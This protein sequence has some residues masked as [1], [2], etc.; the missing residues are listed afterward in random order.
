MSDH[1]NIE[2]VY[3]IGLGALGT[4]Y[5]AKFHD[6]LP[7][8]L[9]IIANEERQRSLK[10]N[11]P[12]VN[13]QEYSFNYITPMEQP[14]TT[15]DLIII[16]VKSSQLDQAIQ[17]IQH[18]VNP[19]TIVISLLNG[20]SSEA[21]IAKHIG[22]SHLLYAYAIGMDAERLDKAITYKNI[23]KIVFGEENN[24]NYSPKVKAL[25]ALFECAGI[26][27]EIPENMLRSLWFKFMVNTGIN[28]SS[29]VLGA[30]YG[31]F[32]QDT[33]AQKLMIMAAKEVVL[34]SAIAGTGLEDAD[35]EKFK[36]IVNTLNPLGKTSMLQDIQA[37]RKSELDLFAGTVISLG[38]E[39][40]IATP[41][42]EILHTII[43]AMEIEQPYLKN[44]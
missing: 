12:S 31:S 8:G 11:P 26:A 18:F 10:A 35:I 30:P 38:K 37:S 5:A 25:Q 3:V 4:M 41:V 15:V 32:Q 33:P 1:T 34:L 23:G 43:S 44:S 21:L 19:G 9:F 20:I 2:T 17:D 29:A 27:H 36:A 42:N 6:I 7:E 28:Q 22:E 24:K 40:G 13:G 16:A 39:Y 14:R